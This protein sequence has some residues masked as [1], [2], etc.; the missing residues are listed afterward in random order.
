ME[1]PE[2]VKTN[3]PTEKKTENKEKNADKATE[4]SKKE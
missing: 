3:A 1:K 2:A 4:G